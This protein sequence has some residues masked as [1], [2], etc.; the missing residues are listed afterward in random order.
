[1]PRSLP[2]ESILI[3]TPGPGSRLVNPIHVTGIADPTFEQVLVVRAVS[4]EG[5]ELA[6][7]PAQ[8]LAEAGQRGPFAA[9]L[10][11][12]VTE[13]T[14]VFIQVYAT[15]PRDG[16]ITHLSSVTVMVKPEGGPEIRPVDSH[17]E[18][19]V[20]DQPAAGGS[21]QGGTAH[22]TGFGLASFEQALLAEVVG[23]DGTV[24]GSQ[25]LLVQAPD[26]GV[27]GP[28]SVDVPYVLSAPG[29]G[30]I[31]V[32]DLSAAFGGDV[33]VSSVEVNLEP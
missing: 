10:S 22:I 24:I 27:P 18:R 20:I 4:A 28:F 21:V 16:G 7:V 14:P 25:S 23:P 15:S 33:H 2:E 11:V 8:I 6:L 3:L 13:S 12:P 19:I 29:P 9:D 31:L 5:T 1:L 32:R 17:L 30:R 26:M